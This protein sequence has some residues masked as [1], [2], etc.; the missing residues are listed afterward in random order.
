M[1]CL[2]KTDIRIAAVVMP[3]RIGETAQNLQKIEKWVVAAEEK[4]A[5][6]ICFPEMSITGYHVQEP[7]QTVAETVPGPSTD[8][9]VAVSRKTG[10]TI[11][12]GLAEKDASGRLY[13]THVVITPSGLAGAYRK[14]HLGPPEKDFF[15]AGDS[16]PVFD[17]NGICFGIQLCYDAHFPELA[18]AMALKGA[19]VIFMPHASPR[20][21]QEKKRHSWMRHL[22]ARAYDNSLFVVACNPCGDNGKGLFFPGVAM[23]IGPSGAVIE[24]FAGEEGH[25][26]IADAKAD[27]LKNI[28]SHRMTYFLPNRRPDIYGM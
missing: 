19:D 15:T 9:L 20:G 12:A 5:S 13:A 25:M 23:V 7:I 11:L 28:R 4:H 21:T 10:V 22:P 6:M 16:A 3:S 17:S 24:S 27:V 18:A 2:M 8:F 14:T 1:A 26:L